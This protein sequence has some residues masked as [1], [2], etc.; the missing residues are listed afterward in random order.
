MSNL[1]Y[2]NTGAWDTNVI[3]SFFDDSI[4]ARIMQVP[5]SRHRGVDF[6]S[7]PH[8]KYGVYSMGL[9]YNLVRSQEVVARRIE[10]YSLTLVSLQEGFFAPTAG[11]YADG[12][13]RHHERP[14]NGPSGQEGRRCSLDRPDGMPSAQLWPSGQ[15]RAVSQ[16]LVTCNGVVHARPDPTACRRLSL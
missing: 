2:P 16:P 7:W 3:R 8:A 9:A 15:A 14:P 6:P 5:L 12:L 10:D 4:S 11:S 13:E 1:T